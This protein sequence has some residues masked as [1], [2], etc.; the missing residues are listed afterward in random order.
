LKLFRNIDDF[1]KLDYPVVT[2]GG[3][4]GV[5]TG[6][7]EILKKLVHAAKENNGESIIITFSP[8]P[9]LVLY[10]SND[11]QILTTDDE[12]IEQLGYSGIDNL[13]IYPFT[14]E[15]SQLTSEE[16]IKNILVSKLHTRKLIIGYNHHFGNERKGD[17]DKLTEYSRIYNFEIER[18]PEHIINNIS[19]SSTKIRGYLNQGKISFANSLLGYNYNITGRVIESNKIGIQL[20]FPTANIEVNDS[21]KLVP[22]PGVYA[23][24]VKYNEI[25]F[26]GMLYIG[27]RPTLGEASTLRPKFAIEVNIFDFNKEIYNENITI[28]FIDRTRDDKKFDS[29]DALKEQI[30]ADKKTI[31]EILNYKI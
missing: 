29:L 19:V 24:R 3:F 28:Y 18:I 4:D 20:G 23:V 16:F 8:H 25:M 10:P 12:K 13:I 6:H 14:K 9:R 26:D 15:F 31:I 27:T 30:I 17:F 2:T 21:S 1:P 5:H 11:I 7:K 22:P